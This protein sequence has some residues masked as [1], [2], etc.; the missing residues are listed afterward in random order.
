MR[1][2]RAHLSFGSKTLSKKMGAQVVPKYTVKVA[3]SSLLSAFTT[4]FRAQNDNMFCKV[5][6]L[7]P[8]FN[9]LEHPIPQNR[10]RKYIEFSWNG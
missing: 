9:V 2:Q 5:V 3:G 4:A 7:D 6:V 1:Y 8:F 10:L